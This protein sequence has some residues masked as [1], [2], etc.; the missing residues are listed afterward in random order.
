[1]P[2]LTRRLAGSEPLLDRPLAIARVPY[3]FVHKPNLTDELYRLGDQACVIPSFS[4]DGMALALHSAALAATH[5]LRGD[6]PHVYHAALARD[7]SAP[8]RRAMWLYRLGSLPIGPA[9]LRHT[10]RLWP[11]LLRHVASITRV[12]E[13]ALL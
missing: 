3:G 6:K 10:I 1:V 5:F 7:V 8:I 13:Q 11:A 9:L 12:P 4:G 2:H